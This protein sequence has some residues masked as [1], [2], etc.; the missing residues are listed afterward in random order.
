[1]KSTFSFAN[2]YKYPT[3]INLDTLQ[4]EVLKPNEIM[5]VYGVM[6][7]STVLWLIRKETFQLF[8]L[9][10]SEETLTEKVKAIRLAVDWQLDTRTFVRL[11]IEKTLSDKKLSELTYDLYD[12]LF[13]YP[14][15]PLVEKANTVYIVPTGVLYALPFGMLV[16]KPVKR[17]NDS[18]HYLIEDTA[19]AYLSS[20]SLL[21]NLRD[22]KQRRIQ[23]AKYP[24]LAFANPI[25]QGS[26]FM[27]L[28]NTADEARAIAKIFGLPEKNEHLLLNEQVSVK[29]VIEFNE[30]ERLDDYQYLLFAMHGVIPGKSNNVEQP[31]LVLSHPKPNGEGYLKMADVFGLK[32]NAK[33]VSLSACN[34]GRGEQERGE[35]VMGLTRAFMYAGTPTVAVT[36]W[37]VNTY[38]AEQLNVSFFEQLNKTQKPALALQAVK[39][40][41]LQ[42][43]NKKYRHP[44]Y[45]APMVLFGDGN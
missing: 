45:W 36:L 18:I 26:E 11:K 23:T 6:Q 13:P 3:P 33:L 38:S 10:I 35:G 22:A 14:V 17:P 42:G 9:P 32:L 30:K 5:L 34:T 4:Q 20:A 1:M 25:Y 28:P 27:P 37:S 43:K 24:L 39:L 7:D 2:D 40:E 41:M 21:K 31:A 44:Y 19:I 16:T 15:R 8:D 29:K 12:S